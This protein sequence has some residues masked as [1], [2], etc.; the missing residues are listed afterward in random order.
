MEPA[1]IGIITNSDVQEMICTL[2]KTKKKGDLYVPGDNGEW[3][4]ITD[5]EISGFIKKTKGNAINKE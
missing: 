5:R 2:S 4:K 1:P 3:R